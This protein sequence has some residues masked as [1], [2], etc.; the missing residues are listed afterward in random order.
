MLK[1][2]R[3]GKI[4]AGPNTDLGIKK[5]NKLLLILQFVDKLSYSILCQINN[6]Y[7]L[8]NL[9]IVCSLF[10]L[11]S[12]CVKFLSRSLIKMFV[13]LCIVTLRQCSWSG[14]PAEVRPTTWQLLS[15]CTSV[16][17]N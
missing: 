15:V 4:L 16:Q 7:I 11:H 5:Y 10:L 8:L 12:Y 13:R 1:L 17:Q 9:C 14:I 2:E 3:F 6:I